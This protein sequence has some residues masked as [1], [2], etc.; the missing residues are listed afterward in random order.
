V[1][2]AFALVLLETLLARFADD[3]DITL[4]AFVSYLQ[5]R[6]FL[7]EG[8]PVEEARRLTRRVVALAYRM[9][10]GE[11]ASEQTHASVDRAA[12]RLLGAVTMLEELI[13]S[14]EQAVSKGTSN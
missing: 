9:A 13:A 3:I 5:H 7:L 1:R 14:E 4:L 12:E 2:A 6:I 8:K 11:G 10:L